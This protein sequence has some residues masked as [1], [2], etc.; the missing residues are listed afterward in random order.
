VK[1]AASLLIP[2]LWTASLFCAAQSKPAPEPRRISMSVRDADLKDLLRAAGEGT[3]YNL[4][5]DPDLDTR[6]KGIDLKGV[7]FQ[8]ILDEIL[9]SFGFSYAVSGRTVHIQ[10]AE[11][12]MRFYQVDLLSMRRKGA[13]DF[14]VSAAG[15]TIQSGTSGGGSSSGGSGSSGQSSAYTSSLSSGNGVDPW[16][17]LQMGLSTLVFGEPLQ[18]VGAADSAS[19][20]TMAGPGSQ[21]FSRNGRTLLIHPESGMVVVQAESSI[22]SR[23]ERYLQEMKRRTGHQVLLEARIVEVTLGNDSQIGVDWNSLLTPGAAS[24]GTGTDIASSFATGITNNANVGASQGLFKL[25]AQNARITATLSALAREGRLQV[26]SSPRIS[27]MNNQKAILRVVREEA[28]FLESTQNTPNGSSGPIVTTT[29][30]PL[31]VPVGIVLDIQP[32]VAED[33][34][35]TLAV[36]PSV[37]EVVSVNTFTAADGTTSTLPVVDRRDLDTVVRMKNGETLVLA[38]IIKNTESVDDRGVPWLR[39]IPIIGNLF[40]KREKSKQ[41]T[42]LAIFITP[43]LLEDTAQVQAQKESTEKRLE[44]S[45]AELD[46]QPYMVPPVKVP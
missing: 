3:D 34:T 33:G 45:G 15:Q 40:S 43:T 32:Q 5:F 25:V 11:G 35:I 31:V 42:E 30:T 17:E 2:L 8:E 39:R 36:N 46:P 12:T 23:V 44:N 27:T 28:Y 19:G 24:G 1:Y 21:A 6:V 22:Q 37:S 4:L 13:K 38:G 26:L 20:G 18:P 29:V 9:P 7:T 14:M 10:K 41:R 16:A